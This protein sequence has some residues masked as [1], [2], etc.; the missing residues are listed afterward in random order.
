[1]RNV[2]PPAGRLTPSDVCDDIDDFSMTVN[3]SEGAVYVDVLSLSSPPRTD[4]L[5]TTGGCF[6]EPE[7]LRELK[8]PKDEL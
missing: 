2:T 5:I 3:I 8:D 6:L 1:L 4:E 7:I